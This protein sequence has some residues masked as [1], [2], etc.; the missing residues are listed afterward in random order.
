MLR[1]TI[2]VNTVFH[3]A[4]LEGADLTDT[5]LTGTI[6]TDANLFRAIFPLDGEGRELAIYGNTMMP[7][8]LKRDE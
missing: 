5:V 6:F 2:L 3:H 4:N 8:G 1:D 7:D